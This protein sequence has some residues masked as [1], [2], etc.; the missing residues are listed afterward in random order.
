MSADGEHWF[1][2]VTS[3]AG[4]HP[5]D[6]GDAKR[7]RTKR[8]GK[9]SPGKPRSRGRYNLDAS[10]KEAIQMMLDRK[11]VRDTAV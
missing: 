1:T 2:I 6:A 5:A 7:S 9:R 10:F 11:D 3:T 4:N 8:A